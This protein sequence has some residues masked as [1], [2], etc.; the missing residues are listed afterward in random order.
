MGYQ[1]ACKK[2]PHAPVGMRGLRLWF[3]VI[4][5]YPLFLLSR[6]STSF[7]RRT[8]LTRIERSKAW[9]ISAFMAFDHVG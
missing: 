1:N 7:T 6:S 2:K 5:R 4:V 9:D 8:P 3:L